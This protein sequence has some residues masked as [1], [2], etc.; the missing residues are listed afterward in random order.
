MPIFNHKTKGRVLFIHIPKTAGASIEMWLREAGYELDKINN[1]SGSLHQHAPREEYEKWGDFDY[2]FTIVR[3]PMDRFVSVLG[4]KGIHASA[5]NRTARDILEKYDRGILTT[6]WG[7]H[8]LPQVDFISDDTVILKFEEDF[9]PKL[10]KILG[11]PGPYPHG[12]KTRTT[13]NASHLSDTVKD[14]VR[15]LYAEDYKRFGYKDE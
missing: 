5:G 15:R 8:L 3:H 11:I 1:W 2:K 6:Q 9:F 10:S 13:L 7:N 14:H 12:N 4:F